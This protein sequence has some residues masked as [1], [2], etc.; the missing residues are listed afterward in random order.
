MQVWVGV[1]WGNS[2]LIEGPERQGKLRGKVP[3]KGGGNWL[4][5]QGGSL[6]GARRRDN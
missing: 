5:S 6:S 1:R 2:R 3:E 4:P